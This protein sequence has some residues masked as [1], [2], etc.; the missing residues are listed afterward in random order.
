LS[1]QQEFL[2]TLFV[3]IIGKSA[4]RAMLI[5]GAALVNRNRWEYGRLVWSRRR[6]FYD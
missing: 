2:A 3:T 6:V 4:R 1:L 5:G